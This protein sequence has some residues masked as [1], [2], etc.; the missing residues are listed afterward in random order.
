VRPVQLID[1][2]S[3]SSRAEGERDGAS[4]WTPVMEELTR[5]IL[6]KQGQQTVGGQQAFLPPRSEQATASLKALDNAP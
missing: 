2:G 6:S 1:A 3:G 5:F 4:S